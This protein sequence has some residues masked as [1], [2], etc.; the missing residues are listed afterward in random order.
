MREVY[1][2]NFYSCCV[3]DH[4]IFMTIETPV[5]EKKKAYHLKMDS[6]LAPDPAMVTLK[7]NETFDWLKL[8][9]M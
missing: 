7:G 4:N 6:I 1:A 8:T 3:N 2:D 5:Q 9:E